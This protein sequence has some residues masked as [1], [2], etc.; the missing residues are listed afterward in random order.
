MRI[1][2]PLFKFEEQFREDKFNKMALKIKINETGSLILDPNM[3][4]PFVRIHIID[5][6]TYKYLAKSRAL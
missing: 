1:I 4:H 6:D 5:M 3:L 2:P